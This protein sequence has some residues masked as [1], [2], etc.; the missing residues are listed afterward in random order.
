M[1]NQAPAMGIAIITLT[2]PKGGKKKVLPS[3]HP[4]PK[5]LLGDVACGTNGKIV[6]RRKTTNLDLMIP[7]KLG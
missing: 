6:S 5:F 4:F 2:F 1:F 3:N 7:P